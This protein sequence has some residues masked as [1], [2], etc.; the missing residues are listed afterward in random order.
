MAREIQRIYRSLWRRPTFFL[1]VVLTMALGIGANSAIFSVIDAV[2]LQPLPYPAGDRLMAVYESNARQ[3]MLREPV[4]PVRL[5]EWNRMNQAFAGIAGAYTENQAEN[6]GAL[7]ERLVCARV[8]PRFFSV[9]GT[10]PLLG[11][12][13]SPEEDLSNGP[14]AAVISERLWKRRFQADPQVIGK[15][16]RFADRSFPIVGVLPDS[17]RFPADDVDVWL[18]AKLVDAVMRMREARYYSAVG[19]LKEGVARSTAQA[20]LA[21]VQARLGAQFPATDAKWSALVEPLK[22]ETVGGVRRSLWILFGA[23][24]L[25][26]LIACAN[27]ACL[28]LAQ[29]SR[30]EREIAVRLALGAGRG[31]VAVALLLEAVCAALPGAAAGLALAVWGAGWFRAAAI[32]LPRASEI[33]L[34]W[35]IVLFTLFTTLATALLFGLFPALHAA[36]GDAAGTLAQGSRTQ[37]A[38]Q[39][40]LL[41]TLVS[42]QIALA[43]VLLVGAGLLIRTLSRLGQVSLGFQPDKVLTLRISASWD[44]K[45]DMRRVQ[46]RMWRTLEALANIPGVEA[47]ALS[48]ELPGGGQDYPQPFRIAGRNTEGQGEQ[49]LADAQS[50]SPDYFRVLGVPILAGETCRINFDPQS[51]PRVMVNRSLADRYMSGMNPVQQHLQVGRYDFEIVGVTSDIREHGYAKDPRPTIYYCELPGFFPDPE[52]LVKTAASPASLVES[53]RRRMQALEPN[54]AVYDTRPLTGYLT[55][56]LAEKRF[57]TMLL[58]LFGLT[59]MLLATVGLYG[60]TSF[61]VSQR[62]REIGLRAALGAQPGQILAHVFRQGA[63]MTGAGVLAGL[64]AAG[65]LSRSIASLLFGIAPVDPIAFAAA[66]TVLAAVAAAAIWAPARRATRV[67]PMEALRQE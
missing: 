60:V 15:V 2:L 22:D 14:A 43:I 3:K 63:V 24:S 51:T 20:D 53:V 48:L 33:H 39:H 9:L 12:G 57:Q 16:L 34:D 61:F 13:L 49:M 67:D 66:P 56:S 11:R 28:L 18:P 21:A 10:P 52:Y 8:S 55:S 25:V 40:R 59:A 32:G 50:V 23:V 37:V 36:R 6:S 64:F 54:R 58:S 65:L 45:R 35:R 44:E 41:R 42:T 46:Q 5:E 19:R 7:P 62:S 30:R 47:A 38:G 29:A 17:F 27:V 26:L 1:A 31:R 4:A